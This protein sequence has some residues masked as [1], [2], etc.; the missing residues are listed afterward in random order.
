MCKSRTLSKLKL[1]TSHTRMKAMVWNWQPNVLCAGINRTAFRMS[2]VLCVLMFASNFVILA[3]V[4]I[5]FTCPRPP[6]EVLQTL[7]NS[8][9][10]LLPPILW[11]RRWRSMRW[12]QMISKSWS[13]ALFQETWEVTEEEHLGWNALSVWSCWSCKLRWSREGF[14]Q[15]IVL[16]LSL[17]RMAGLV[18][19]SNNFILI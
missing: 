12:Q 18:W 5:H 2:K 11:N 9:Q 6:S 8:S 4:H 17:L 15:L 16:S 14:T 19:W 1:L 3:I 7:Q 10:P 13:D